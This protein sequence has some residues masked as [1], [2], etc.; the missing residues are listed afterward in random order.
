MD[1]VVSE[2]QKGS[3]QLFKRMSNSKFIRLKGLD[4]PG[5]RI[6]VTRQNRD[7]FGTVLG[8]NKTARLD[9]KWDMRCPGPTLGAKNP[10][11]AINDNYYLMQGYSAEKIENIRSL[12]YQKG[13][14]II[15]NLDGN[16]FSGE[17]VRVQKK[18]HKKNGE[19]YQLLNVT[20]DDDFPRSPISPSQVELA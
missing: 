14:K 2:K 6:K 10:Y 20:W 16:I 11:L 13:Q 1:G 19:Y 8:V 18:F 9:V 5:T 12:G 15:L 4:K 3:Y 7:Y 17:I